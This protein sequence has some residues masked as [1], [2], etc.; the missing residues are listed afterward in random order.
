MA[1][2][3]FSVFTMDKLLAILLILLPPLAHLQSITHHSV[4][5]PTLNDF[6]G[7]Q[8]RPATPETH[9]KYLGTTAVSTEFAHLTFTFD[10]HHMFQTV[11]NIII[12][13]MNTRN[14][15]PHTVPHEEFDIL[16]SHFQAQRAVA[17]T[18]PCRVLWIWTALQR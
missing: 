7:F 6:V 12:S 2:L 10:L 4:P 1:G 5:P 17:S 3:T 18:R 13:L 9:F 8:D 15:A 16:Y 11:N 14:N